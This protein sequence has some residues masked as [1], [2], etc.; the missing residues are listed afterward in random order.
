M[1]KFHVHENKILIKEQ[2]AAI[3]SV[4]EDD[5]SPIK[6]TTITHGVK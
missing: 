6:E 5:M 2:N 4:S 1:P 3:E